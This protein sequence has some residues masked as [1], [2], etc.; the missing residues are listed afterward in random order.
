MDNIL[1]IIE[2]SGAFRVFVADTTELVGKAAKIHNLS[3][4]AA[5]ALGTVQSARS[6]AFRTDFSHKAL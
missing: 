2:K 5:A 6:V 3:P 4:V 1:R